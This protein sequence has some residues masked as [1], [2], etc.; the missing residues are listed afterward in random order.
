MSTFD[1][2]DQKLNKHRAVVAK[3]NAQNRPPCSMPFPP[4]ALPMSWSGSTARSTAGKSSPSPR[5]PARHVLHCRRP[6]LP[7]AHRHGDSGFR[8]PFLRG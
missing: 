8:N 3:A 1:D 4:Q 5:G 7:V 6:R 2:F